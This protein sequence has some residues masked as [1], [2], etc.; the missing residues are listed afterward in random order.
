MKSFSKW[1]AVWA[2]AAA[3]LAAALYAGTLSHPPVW[4]DHAF[5]FGQPFLRDCAN[6]GRVLAPGAWLRPLPVAG[7]ARPA[8][9]L[10]VL[11]DTCAGG[12]AR[13]A[14]RVSNLFWH[15]AGAATVAALAWELTASAP[16]C[17][18]AGLLF[19][20]H[21][22]H[23]EAVN[24]VT[25][26][27]DQMCLVFMI[28]ALLAYREWLR[29]EG[30]L[31]AA[32]GSAA[33]VFA[34]AALLSKEMAVTLPLLALL[35]DALAPA[36]DGRR[37]R[38][39]RWATAAAAALVC[40]YL[41]FR[42]PRS[43]YVMRSTEDFFSAVRDGGLAARATPRPAAFEDPPWAAVYGDARARAL[44][45][46]AVLGR[47]LRRLAWPSDLQGDYAPEVVVSPL[48]LDV[49]GAWALWLLV[50]VAAWK[51]RRRPAASFGL[52]WAAVCFLPVCGLV[53]LYNLEADRYLYVPTA[54]A[55]L[56]AAAAFDAAWRSRSAWARP[57]AA[58]VLAGLVAA[59]AALVLRRNRVYSSDAALLESVLAADPK[60]PRAHL[61]LAILAEDHGRLAEARAHLS[62]AA[63]LAPGYARASDALAR[64]DARHPRR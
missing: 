19:A 37:R 32:T 16:A 17:A 49:L 29:S 27:S 43:G 53:A 9:L 36:G 41:A 42:A 59:G 48:R 28:L 8:W 40:L 12:G 5:V 58:A 56:A 21:P 3:A 50:V 60:V 38:L 31:S 45:M 39:T 47:E 4:D 7:S 55:C 13:V 62:A 20:A 25:F 30:A 6:V 2:G 26:R 46:S 35:S 23:V 22:A 1:S 11:L 34:A 57:A 18:A 63:S 61:G 51:L 44:T 52:A 15:A 24:I 64:F 14:Y 10:T 54:G 33:L